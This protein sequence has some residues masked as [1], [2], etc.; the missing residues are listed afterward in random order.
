ME[1]AGDG[2]GGGQNAG[3]AGFNA[4][5]RSLAPDGSGDLYVG[6][7]F[8]SYK[9]TPVNRVVRLNVDGTVDVAFDDRNRVQR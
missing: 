8:T 1:V 7:A 9:G 6:G 5:V 4:P 3:A 2:D